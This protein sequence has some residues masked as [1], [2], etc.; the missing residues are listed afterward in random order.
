MDAEELRELLE[1]ELGT[2]DRTNRAAAKFFNTIG[3]YAPTIGIIGTVISL[4]HVLE[5]LSSPDKLGHSIAG[6]FVATLWGVLSAN[7]LW[8]P[9][10]TRLG[11]LADL[12]S[13]RMHLVMEGMLAVQA[14]SQPR[15]LGERLRA[16]VPDHA[17][18]PAKGE[19]PLKEA[20]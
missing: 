15:V 11:R 6:A 10:G 12:D 19:K 2:R 9:I 13:E 4:T 8:L 18:K 14:G 20:A 17:L 7:L 3:G 1:D 5:N 16:M